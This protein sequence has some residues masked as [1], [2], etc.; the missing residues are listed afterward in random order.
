MTSFAR[1]DN[2]C[3][4]PISGLDGVA[5]ASLHGTYGSADDVP[6]Q[7]AALR[8]PDSGLRRDALAGLSNAVIHQGTRWQVGAGGR[9]AGT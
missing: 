5:W 9:N 7:I 1:G 8:S 4:D 3:L 2:P 6:G